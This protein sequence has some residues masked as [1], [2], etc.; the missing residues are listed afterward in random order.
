MVKNWFDL[1]WKYRI[2]IKV[3]HT[4]IAG[5]SGLKNFPIKV[6]IT[7]GNLAKKAHPKGWDF[8]FT[9]SDGTTKL[10]HEIQHLDNKT[11]KLIA[12]VKIPLLSPFEDTII[13]LY[14]G[15]PRSTNQ[16]NGNVWNG[17]QVRKSFKNNDTP[18]KNNY[19]NF[20]VVDFIKVQIKILESLFNKE[21]FASHR[22][23]I[24]CHPA[25]D[26]WKICKYLLSKNC[27]LKFPQDEKLLPLFCKILLDN[28]SIIQCTK[29]N[30]DTF[31][32]GKLANYGDI[33]VQKRIKNTLKTLDGYRSINTELQHAAWHLS[34]NHSV[35]AFEKKG[36]DQRVI[37]PSY[38]L[39]IFA[40][41][42]TINKET[43]ISRIKSILS[44]ANK[45][46]KNENS[47][48]YGLVVID[49][50]AK[51]I[52]NKKLTDSV[53]VELKNI[54]NE[55]KKILSNKYYKSISAALLFW[56]KISILKPKKPSS[57]KGIY[58]CLR[59]QSILI[60]HKNP[61]YGL[62]EDLGNLN[63]GNTIEMNILTYK[64]N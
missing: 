41:C 3:D 31:T 4:K 32:M 19:D 39:P 48:A 8:L 9:S 44:K 24:D 61:T 62:N 54:I 30:I 21:W 13:Y 22:R 16:E 37:I 33:E 12:W 38:K 58:V 10:N 45:Q 29:G 53:P 25:Y 11:G 60:Q 55:T 42:K 43:N 28:V 17:Y 7:N 50:S 26:K 27:K 18:D 47:E 56:P 49:L 5:N 35:E 36:S 57:G 64:D 15:N 6:E 52:N 34:H 46:I 51:T 40:E 23:E 1:K 2:P 59:T 14:Y 63:F 20:K